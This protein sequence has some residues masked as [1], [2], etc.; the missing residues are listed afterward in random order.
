MNRLSLEVKVGLVVTLTVGLV[1]AFLF[2]LGGYNPFS[3]T[4][5]I[6]VLY[7]FAS[8]IEMGSPVRVSGVKVG[9]VNAIRF[10]EA[11]HSFQG[12][13][14][15][16]ALTLLIDRRVKHL[17]REDSRFYI[18]M[19]GIIGEK[20]IDIIPGTKG[21]PELED[22]TAVRGIDPPRIEQFISQGYDIFERLGELVSRIGPED[23]DK[24]KNLLDN[25]VRLTDN[26]ASLTDEM[27][28]KAGPALAELQPMLQD[29]HELVKD[30]KA[31]TAYLRPEEKARKKELEEKAEKLLDSVEHL[32]SVLER[33]DRLLARL[34]KETEGLTKADVERIIR[35]FLQQGI[36]INVGTITGKPD[37]PLPPPPSNP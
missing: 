5:E 33:L 20:Y 23:R 37:Y 25:L 11:G 15:S 13:E 35:E 29:T 18:N 30:L 6:K 3:T 26:L 4:Y 1:L 31:A 7:N 34:E 19:A 14:V 9:K 22:G 21:Y 12:E 8:G 17:I 32:A 16:L 28:G 36:T 24:L 27:H 10:F 2:L